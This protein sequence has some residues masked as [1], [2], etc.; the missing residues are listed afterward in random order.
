M[1]QPLK[2]Q[3]QGSGESGQGPIAHLA[4]FRRPRPRVSVLLDS[5]PSQVAIEYL[6]P[7][8]VERW[9]VKLASLFVEPPQFDI[10]ILDSRR[11]GL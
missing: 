6:D 11:L 10:E 9:V 3:F 5:Q 4:S 2:T 8:S 1:T 7:L